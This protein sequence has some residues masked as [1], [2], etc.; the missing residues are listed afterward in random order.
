MPMMYVLA[1]RVNVLHNVMM[2]PAI[3]QFTAVITGKICNYVF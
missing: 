2:V 1:H 3:Y